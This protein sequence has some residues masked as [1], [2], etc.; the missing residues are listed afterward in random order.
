MHNT[1]ALHNVT[2]ENMTQTHK[3]KQQ[4]KQGT[5]WINAELNARHGTHITGGTT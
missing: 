3:H 1:K 2:R 4:S 5:E